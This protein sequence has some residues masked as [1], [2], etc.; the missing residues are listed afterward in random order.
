MR[1]LIVVV[2]LLSACSVSEEG[3][4]QVFRCPDCSSAYDGYTTCAFFEADS[5]WARPQMLVDDEQYKG[6]GTAIR[7]PGYMHHKIT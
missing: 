6:V 7:L 1:K 3:A 4:V 5:T 2:L